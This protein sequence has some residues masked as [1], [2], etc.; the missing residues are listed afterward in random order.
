VLKTEHEGVE[1]LRRSEEDARHRLT[2]ARAEAAAVARRADQRISKLHTA[3]LQKIERDILKLA[4]A[5]DADGTGV[6]E[7]YDA[8][9]LAEAA[10]RV[11]AKLTGGA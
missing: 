7:A 3:Y 2:Q 4:A 1:A 5:H 8:A 10:R 11:A 6:D 9:S